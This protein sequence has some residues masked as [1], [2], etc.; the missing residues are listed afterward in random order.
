MRLNAD[1]IIKKVKIIP[2]AIA[3]KP[4]LFS[5]IALS[6]ALALSLFIFYKDYIFPKEQ[7]IPSQLLIKESDYR[8]FLEIERGQAAESKQIGDKE[9]RDPFIDPSIKK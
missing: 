2:I 3:K 4:L 7:E 5:F 6:L 1:K 9:Y 8:E